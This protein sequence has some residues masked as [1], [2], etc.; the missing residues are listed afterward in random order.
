MAVRTKA[1]ADL[2]N[3]DI[4]VPDEEQKHETI[5]IAPPRMKTIVL[6]LVGETPLMI[7]RFSQKARNKIMETQRA[8]TQAKSKKV[9]EPKNFE[10]DYE[11][12]KY[13][14]REKDGKTWCGINAA[15][16][17]N[18][19]ISMCKLVGFYMTRAKLSIFVLPDGLDYI[20]KTPLVRIY[21]E[22]EMNVS[23][24]RNA[25]G[26]IDLRARALWETWECNVKVRFDEDQFSVVD[27]VNLF[28]RI[29]LQGGVG[30]G[31]PDG[32]DGN[33]CGNGLFR[34]ELAAG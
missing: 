4:A 24:V 10:E 26:V 21:G 34:V 18:A 15:S 7:L 16:F 20:D 25:S 12:A 14:C 11:G 6:K 13:I 23:P 27:V 9:R 31:R 1:K 5:T 28:C 29:G 17:R 33:G 30:E 22:P 8:G 19:A 2:R 3:G 32:R